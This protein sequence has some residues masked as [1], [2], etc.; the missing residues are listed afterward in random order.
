MS[1]VCENVMHMTFDCGVKVRV[2]NAYLG[3]YFSRMR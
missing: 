2:C 1:D 3:R